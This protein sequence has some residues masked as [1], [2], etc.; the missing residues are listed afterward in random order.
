MSRFGRETVGRYRQEL[1]DGVSG[2]VLEIGAGN[3][4]N[5]AHYPAGVS[6]VVAVEPEPHLRK[7]A[8]AAAARAPVVISVQ[9]GVGE[10]LPFADGSFDV[11]TRNEAFLGHLVDVLGRHPKHFCDLSNF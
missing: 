6:E 8:F 11:E 2:R 4:D 9:D 3:G 1:L 5:F 7:L 10:R